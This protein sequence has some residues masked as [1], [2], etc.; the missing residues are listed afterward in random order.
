MNAIRRSQTI[1]TP[2]MQRD[3][4]IATVMK[5]GV[6]HVIL[7]LDGGIALHCT[8]E[9]DVEITALTSV[10]NDRKPIWKTLQA[11]W[12]SDQDL[13][14]KA[15]MLQGVRRYCLY[16]Y[17]CEDFLHELIGIDRGSPTRNI[18]LAAAALTGI[19]AIAVRARA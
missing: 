13:V 19:A 14:T 5:H 3:Y 18:V 11:P 1:R 15:R 6:R 4:H 7:V 12:V 17:N 16:R 10:L 2:S 9:N 8:P